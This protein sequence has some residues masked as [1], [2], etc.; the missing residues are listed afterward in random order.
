MFLRFMTRLLLI[1]AISHFFSLLH[2]QNYSNRERDSL[3]IAKNEDALEPDKVLHA[4]PLYIDLIRDLG[5]RKGEREWNVGY[6]LTDFD[7]FDEYEFLIEYEFAVI[8]RLGLEIEVPVFLYHA[9]GDD[10]K[11][12]NR[13]ESIKTA[14]QWSFY[15]NQQCKTSMA[16][17]YINE[18]LFYP[19]KQVED[20]GLFEGNLF[21]PFLVAAKRWG[22]HWH[23][24][25]YTGPRLEYHF[26]PGDWEFEYEMHLNFHY[27]VPGTGNFLGVE[28]NQYFFGEQYSGVFRPQ[29]RVDINEHL[30]LG[31]V[32]GI[33]ADRTQ[34]RLSFFMRIIYEPDF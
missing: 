31:I 8:D 3:R 6:G 2:A 5:A 16:L 9:G 7:A 34:E 13:I 20:Q 25:I 24:L 27:M 32:T 30:L 26:K 15:V 19:L 14:A 23:S 11:P 12:D 10:N 33:P 28:Y 4:E 21:N 29:A 17:G 18:L 1:F 22:D